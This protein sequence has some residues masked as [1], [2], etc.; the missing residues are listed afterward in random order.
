[1]LLAVTLSAVIGGLTVEQALA[2]YGDKSVWLVMAAFF[3]SRALMNSGLARRVALFFVRLF[4]KSS[5]GV[6]YA[7]SLSD[8]LLAGMI[9]SNSARSGG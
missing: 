7:L 4:G 3:I 1:M 5:L 2:G 6:T 8:M 9:P